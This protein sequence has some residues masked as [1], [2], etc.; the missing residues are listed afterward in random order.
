MLSSVRN[1]NPS[2]GRVPTTDTTSVLSGS[3]AINKTKTTERSPIISGTEAPAGSTDTHQSWKDTAQAAAEKL[4]STAHAATDK[5]SSTAQAAAATVTSTAQAASDRIASTLPVDKIMSTAQVAG[6]KLSSTA[7]AATDKITSVLPASLTNKDTESVQFYGPGAGDAAKG[8][9]TE[10]GLFINEEELLSRS[11]FPIP[12]DRLVEMAKDVL[13]AGVHKCGKLSRDFCF[14]APFIGPLNR[15]DFASTMET[16]KLDDVFP[17]MSPRIY[18][19]RVDPL[20]PNRVWFTTRPIGTN[21]GYLRAK[22]PI[23]VAPTGKV[24]EL[25]PQ[26]SS[27]SFNE[28]GE[29]DDFTMGYVMDRR[30]GN[31]GGLGGAFG[32]FW[33]IGCPLPYPEGKP[34]AS[35]LQQRLFNSGNPV[36][37]MAMFV[38]DRV[39]SWI[40]PNWLITA[41]AR[42][43][44]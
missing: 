32:F 2:R 31:S 3:T 20:Q 35:S 23:P 8:P 15:D 27:L 7:H 33:A 42:N 5:L 40:L 25:P 4:T 26:T 43:M 14:S 19:I 36:L 39:S 37:Q 12:P 22:L 11:T 18:H 28:R 38:V 21:T 6:D 17:D 29:V 30:L 1:R 44:P 24:V 13:R 10:G 9:G 41:H 34:W 16:M